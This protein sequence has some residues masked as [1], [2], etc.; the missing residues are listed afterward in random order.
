MDATVIDYCNSKG[1]LLKNE[2][3]KYEIVKQIEKVLG[4]SIMDIFEK[5]YT[6]RLLPIINKRP[7]ISTYISYGKY[8]YMYLTKIYN[9]PVCLILEIESKIKGINP[10]IISIITNFK[11]NIFNDTLIYGEIYRKNDKEWYFLA[12]S[13]KLYNKKTNIS[14]LENIKI[15]NFISDS[16]YKYTS[17]NPIKFQ[18]K[19]FFHLNEIEKSI[20]ELDKYHI[21]LKGIKFIGLKNPICF[22]FNTSFYKETNNS[23]KKLINLNTNLDKEKQKINDEYEKENLCGA[24]ENVDVSNYIPKILT[25]ELQKNSNYGV[26]NLYA[27]DNNTLVY[28]GKSRI[29]TIELSNELL[30]LN[31]SKTIVKAVYNYIFKKFTVLKI[32]SG[33]ISY[34]KDVNS[35]KNKTR[36]FLLPNYIDDFNY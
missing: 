17:I 11:E 1:F 22:Y 25:L 24:Y 28:A 16:C 27:N 3:S 8:V 14:Y 34:L 4:Y 10:K 33:L 29:E 26:Y 15:L 7:M 13:I 6:D 18:V 2:R 32:E 23:Y 35:E 12:E 5:S 30:N 20:N 36:M 9:E 31:N 19:K 21:R